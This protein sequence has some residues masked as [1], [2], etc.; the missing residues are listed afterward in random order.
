M[1]LSMYGLTRAL[2]IG[3]LVAAAPLTLAAQQPPP[4][5]GIRMLAR[6]DPATD[7]R[8]FE[9][10]EPM[11]G[12][13]ILALQTALAR[14][15]FDP[16]PLDG[17]LGRGTRGALER[18]QRDRGLSPCGCVSYET[19]VGLG[20]RPLVLQTVIGSA[21][22]AH[23]IE[24]I[25][26]K[27]PPPAPQ[28]VAAPPGGPEA[29][30]GQG[31]TGTE[32]GQAPRYIETGPGWWVPVFPLHP[33]FLEPIRGSGGRGQGEGRGRG[34]AGDRGG[35]L[36]GPGAGGQGVRAGGVRTAPPPS[37]GAPRPKPPP[38]PRPPK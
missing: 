10:L 9:V 14:V 5:T 16:G 22:E 8:T 11:S 34:G 33:P 37:R 3:V 18:F 29:P 19:V 30:G 20:L 25:M 35:I 31:G 36:I 38:R 6:Y 13:E 27:G 15:G 1:P 7:V 17:Q 24:V 23:G 32:P 2:W 4:A 26:P 21:P 28:P 12:S